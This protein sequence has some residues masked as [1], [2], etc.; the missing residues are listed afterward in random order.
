ML[1]KF[2]FKDS[3]LQDLRIIDPKNRKDVTA[4]TAMNLAKRFK[5]LQDE[6]LDS[7][8]DECHDYVV[9]PDDDLPSAEQEINTFWIEMSQQKLANDQL[10]FPKLCSIVKA[11]MAIP[12]SNSEC[13]RVFSC[14]KKIQTSFRSELS[15]ETI[16]SILASKL[17]NDNVC[18]QSIPTKATL[19]MART[20]TKTYCEEHK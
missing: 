12:N 7:L 10:R 15:Q 17:N 5:I 19:Q 2:P 6:D 18:F 16:C 4:E 9:S 1:K 3:L 13:E 11:M 14:L 20:A 8:T